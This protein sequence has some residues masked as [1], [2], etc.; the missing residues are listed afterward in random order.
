MRFLVL[1]FLVTGTFIYADEL[2]RIDAIVND[3]TNLRVQY[4]KV[5]EELEACKMKLLDEQQKNKILLNELDGYTVLSKKEQEYE[6]SV[7]NLKSQI[8]KLKKHLKPE[9]NMDVNNSS[10]VVKEKNN[11]KNQ[12]KIKEKTIKKELKQVSKKAVV[13][14]IQ[15]QE[16][17]PATFRT[18]KEMK[19]YN[20]PMGSELEVWEKGRSFTSNIKSG[21]WIKITGYFVNKVWQ[22]AKKDMWVDSSD[23]IKR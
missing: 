7:K 10:L 2:Q 11:L 23:V 21:D 20:A 22:P 9:D 8:K 18:S 3:I 4:E 1:V 16:M 12:I 17:E 15:E 13:A 19:I 5:K 14:N 6:E